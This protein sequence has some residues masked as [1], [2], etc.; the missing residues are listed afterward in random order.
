MDFWKDAGHF[1]PLQDFGGS[2]FID[3][4]DA[5]LLHIAGLAQRLFGFAGTFNFNTWVSVF[6]Q[7]DPSRRWPAHDPNQQ[8][9]LS[10]VDDAREL[11]LLKRFG[12]NG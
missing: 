8:S 11:E 9:D 12:R 5:A 2:Y 4:D 10:K 6:R 1:T 7:L 3:A